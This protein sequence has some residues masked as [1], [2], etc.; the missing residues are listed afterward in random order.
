MEDLNIFFVENSSI[1]DETDISLN[2]S[3]N[4]SQPVDIGT[5]TA[6]SVSEMQQNKTTCKCKT[7]SFKTTS[8]ENF[9]R[10]KAQFGS[11]QG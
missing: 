2:V 8:R 10:H 3:V 1:L 4:E 6:P 11:A 7:C 5:T 9:S